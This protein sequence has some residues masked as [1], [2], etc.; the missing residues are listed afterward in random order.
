MDSWKKCFWS[1]GHW[2]WFGRV[3]TDR[4]RASMP[5]GLVCCAV[6]WHYWLNWSSLLLHAYRASILIYYVAVD[7]HT[8]IYSLISPNGLY[9]SYSF[10]HNNAGKKTTK[11]IY[12]PSRLW[13]VSGLNSAWLIWL[14]LVGLLLAHSCLCSQTKSVQSLCSP[15]TWDS[16]SNW[17]LFPIP[18]SL[19][20][21]PEHIF[22]LLAEGKSHA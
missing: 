1:K 8:V 15:W 12:L 21:Q 4:K 5:M 7:F 13:G 22:M 3:D 19:T 16:L 18:P 10:P 6:L 20:C 14:G 2:P 17:A 9:F 11:N